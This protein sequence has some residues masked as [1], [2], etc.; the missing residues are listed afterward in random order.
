MHRE[1]DG[2]C[3][4]GDAHHEGCC[5]DFSPR[6]RRHRARPRSQRRILL[7]DLALQLL[8][9]RSG[10]DSK[11]GREQAP[12]LAKDRQGICLTS[13]VV[14]R[15][16]LCAPQTLPVRTFADQRLELGQ[17]L[18][19]PPEHQPRIDSVSRRR[20]P[21][22]LEQPDRGLRERR[23]TK[24][25]QG[26]AAPERQRLRE[27]RLCSNGVP[28]GEL[29]ASGGG[30]P[31]ELVDVELARLHMEPIGAGARCQTFGADLAAQPRD[32]DLQRLLRPNRQPLRP[33]RLDQR[34][35]IDRLVRVKQQ[36]RKQRPLPTAPNVQRP[37]GASHLQHA[38]ESEAHG[39]HLARA[40]HR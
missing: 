10:F 8:E 5:R 26:R 33:E 16:H 18:L 37:A 2:A 29:R 35:R 39:R 19:R 4:C 21:S 1:R 24:V 36:K 17:H 9:L 28:V 15:Q 13:R 20:G 25:C 7:Q 31:I 32:T 27:R 22:F 14:E 12:C 34:V 38:Q 40:F 11:L 30:E 23:E 6:Q 3:Q